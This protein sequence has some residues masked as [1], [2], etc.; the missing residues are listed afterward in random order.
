[1]EILQFLLH[2]NYLTATGTITLKVKYKLYIGSVPSVLPAT[3]SKTHFPSKFMIHSRLNLSGTE[4]WN[5]ANVRKER[6]KKR[7]ILWSLL[8][9]AWPP[10]CRTDRTFTCNRVLLH[11]CIYT[12]DVHCNQTDYNETSQTVSRETNQMRDQS[13]SQ[14]VQLQCGRNGENGTSVPTASYCC[15]PAL[16][17]LHLFTRSVCQQ[18][19]QSFTQ[20]VSVCFPLSWIKKQYAFS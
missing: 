20:Q 17:L 8:G 11:S 9:G 12:A 2:S 18:Q 1:M 5:C 14:T 13:G 15:V 4:W 3:L 16:T 6:F 10:G 7:F 19:R